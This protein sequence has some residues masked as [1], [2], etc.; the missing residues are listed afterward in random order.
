MFCNQC[1]QKNPDN[2]IFCSNC[3]AR[4][5]LPVMRPVQ[6]VYEQTPAPRQPVY[7]H[8]MQQTLQ[9]PKKNGGLKWLVFLVILVVVAAICI[10]VGIFIGKG[11]DDEEEDRNQYV[12]STEESEE[13]IVEVP[14]NHEAERTVMVYMIG[15]NLEAESGLGSQDIGE[16]LLA[17]SSEDFKIVVQ[18]GGSSKWHNSKIKGGRVQRFEIRDN[19]LVELEDLGKVSMVETSTLTDFISFAK[20]KYPAREYVLVMWNH[21]GSVPIGFGSDELFEGELTDVEIGQAIKDADIHFDALIFNACE[22]CSLELFMAIKDNVDYVVAAESVVYGYG[23][24]GSGIDYTSWINLAIDS[25][26]S[27]QDYCEKILDDYVEFLDKIGSQGSM[28]V[29]RMDRVDEVYQAYIDYI[30]AVYEDLKD[31]DGYAAFVQARENCGIYE[32]TDAVDISTLAGKYENAYSTP[33]QNAVTN[34]VVR[35]KSDIS[36][37]HGITVYSPYHYADYYSMGRESFEKL[38]YDQAV[39]DFYDLFASKLLFYNDMLA[40]AGDWYVEQEDSDGGTH[41]ENYELA[42]TEMGDYQAVALNEEDWEQVK[43]VRM[44][45]AQDLDEVDLRYLY[46]SASQYELD[47]NGYIKVAPPQYWLFINDY[48]PTSFC[49]SYTREDEEWYQV[50]FVF[51]YV[52]GEEAYIRVDS[53]QDNPDGTIVGYYFC[54]FETDEYDEGHIFVDDDIVQLAAVTYQEGDEKILPI[55]VELNGVELYAEFVPLKYGEGEEVLLFYEIEDVY[56][57]LYSTEVTTTSK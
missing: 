28:S 20:E 26:V 37:G 57:N 56:G 38:D 22:M 48:I 53:N 36:Y 49:Q 50:N 3:G 31:G 43:E 40:Y 24:Y 1:G 45:V 15:S 51:A 25:E 12:E 13:N 29:I 16:M 17:E 30:K 55:G 41:G 46:G 27:T 2:L 35:T 21:G 32:G 39:I 33:L 42:Y 34:A 52:N 4:L 44:Y 5:P 7:E 9:E 11:N 8:P 6:P 19:R 14:E 54:D 18:T 47:G 23:I 10:G